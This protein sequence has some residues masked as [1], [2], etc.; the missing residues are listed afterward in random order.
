MTLRQLAY[1]V[2][3]A[4]EKNFRRAAEVSHVSQPTLS[5]GLRELEQELGVV[6]VL[7]NR[8]RFI[9]LT[10]EGRIAVR[11]AQQIVA[12]S[13]TLREQV[14]AGLDQIAGDLRLGVIPTGLPLIPAI[15]AVLRARH[16]RLRIS[17]H[18]LTAS[19]ILR[20][21]DNLELDAGVVYL[22]R[23]LP[24]RFRVLSNVEEK[25][26]LA[27]PSTWIVR[28]ARQISWQEAAHLPLGL[29][30]PDMHNRHLIDAVFAAEHT[31]PDVVIEADS[32][33]VLLN[34]VDAGVCAT[35]I[36]ETY[37]QQR[38]SW[39]NIRTLPLSPEHANSVVFIASQREPIAPVVAAFAAA[40]EHG[41]WVEG[42]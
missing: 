15:S 7:R 9:E 39:R 33:H 37:L 8:H 23:D 35:V 5:A 31:K 12:D 27:L 6:L 10:D 40:L 2:A 22:Q 14:K 32:L 19:E 3:L 34:H 29:L 42:H 24:R 4:R 21:L 17:V 25:Y 26:V 1:L 16:P 36:P 28:E 11:W 13:H 41:V 30:T 20:R 38:A 18:S